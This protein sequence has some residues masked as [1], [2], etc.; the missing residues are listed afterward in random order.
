M[1]DPTGCI[2]SL[3]PAFERIFG[4][5]ADEVI[6]RQLDALISSP[7]SESAAVSLSQLVSDQ[8]TVQTVT[9]RDRKDGSRVDVEIFSTPVR[10]MGQW[11]GSL[12]IYHDVSDHVRAAQQAEEANRAKS[13]FLANMSHE[14][15][16]PMNGIIGMLELALDTSLS[17][18]QRDY[19]TTS[20]QSAEALLTLLN[21]ILDFSK[22]EANCLRLEHI[23]FDLRT[24][25][26][27]V[28]YTLANRAQAKGL[29][30]I[31]HVQPELRDRLLGDPSRLRQV[32]IN[33]LGNGIKFT[34]SGEVMVSAQWVAQTEH[35]QTVRFSVIDTGIGIPRSRH[36]AVFERFTQANG[37][38]TRLYGGTGLGLAI[39]KQL[40]DAMGGEIEVDSEPGRGSRFSF[41]LNFERDLSEGEAIE[42]GDSGPSS[43]RGLRVLGVDDNA[44]NRAIIARM[45]E[46]FGCRVE[47][48]AS[49]CQALETLSQGVR[50]GRPFDLV[51]LDMQMPEMD[52][53]ETLE[54]I[55]ADPELRQCKVVIL[56]SIGQR[57]DA[58]ELQAKGCSAYLLKPIKLQTLRRTLEMT[59][60][61]SLPSASCRAPVEGQPA[62][63][64]K[65]ISLLLV[66][67]NPVNQKLALVLLRKAG[68]SVEVVDNGLRA[69]ERLRKRR[70][71]AVLMDIQKPE[72][73]GLE[74]TRL[75]RLQEQPDVHTPIIA[76]TAN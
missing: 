23:P 72:M 17:A 63:D 25:V 19:L 9:Q 8:Q 40:V 36:A 12:T 56:T 57:G 10:V 67:D 45:L 54:R 47:T 58:T 6:G 50:Q 13:E 41:T 62:P 76:M 70:Y 61:R 43:I 65:G 60:G 28:A 75:I 4:H 30:M 24:L 52:G 33:L 37:S 44:T 7:D 49:G 64:G 71:D 27:D 42:S 11:A 59:V 34:E 21:D 32:L 3:N 39:S 16:T 26:E 66:E 22:I 68:Y 73:D 69:V 1:T 18:E 20:L 46:G 48:V 55:K 15:R 5:T 53:E 2:T 35:A 29:E 74:A 38:T 51:L 31:C 14:I